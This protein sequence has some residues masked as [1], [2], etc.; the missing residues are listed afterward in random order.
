MLVLALHIC[1]TPE[2]FAQ[3]PDRLGTSDSGFL[4]SSPPRILSAVPQIS[5]HSLIQERGFDLARL[6]VASH[7]SFERS[8]GLIPYCCDFLVASTLMMFKVFR[9]VCHLFEKVM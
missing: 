7:W 6:Y 1:G 4:V 9:P 3:H 5:V 8:K 2:N